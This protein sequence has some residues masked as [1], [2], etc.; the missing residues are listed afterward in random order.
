MSE[1]TCTQAMPY[2]DQPSVIGRRIPIRTGR[3]CTMI[4]DKLEQRE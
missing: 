4:A 1:D 3:D 2:H